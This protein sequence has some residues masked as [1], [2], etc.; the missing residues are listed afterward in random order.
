MSIHAD[1]QLRPPEPLV[2]AFGEKLR[3]QREQR[4]LA[5]DAISNT[6]KISP[7]MLR[8]LEAEHLDQLPGGVFNKGFVRAYARQVGL[9]EEEAITDYL[10]ALRESQIRQQSILPDF[11]APAGKSSAD[12]V[13]DLR[14]VEPSTQTLR[15]I[16]LRGHDLPCHD[17]PS[18]CGRDH[19]GQAGEDRHEAKDKAEAQRNPQAGPSS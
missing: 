4:G 17:L 12:G 8:A 2:G 15:P 5:L 6:T 1:E 3:K 19:D 13:R 14:S 18:D 10:T 16:D 11:R 7:S 9:D